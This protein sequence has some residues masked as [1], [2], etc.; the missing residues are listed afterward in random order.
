VPS[1]L[2]TVYYGTNTSMLPPAAGQEN[3]YLI[4]RD[5]NNVVRPYVRE[6]RPVDIYPTTASPDT[7][8]YALIGDMSFAVR[9]TRFVG[10][11]TRVSTAV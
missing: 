1:T 7:L 3:L 8:P 9:A 10:R 11:L 5:R 6:A 2:P 4:S